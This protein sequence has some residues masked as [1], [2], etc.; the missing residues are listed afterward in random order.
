LPSIR[1]EVPVLEDGP[2][3]ELDDALAAQVFDEVPVE[4]RLV[5]PAAFRVGTAESQVDRAADL[6]VEQDVADEAVDTEID[7]DS[8]LA[9]PPRAAVDGQDLLEK[10]LV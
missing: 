1:Q 5:L 4:R 2:S 8:E 6:L 9:D 10:L 3:V 7:A